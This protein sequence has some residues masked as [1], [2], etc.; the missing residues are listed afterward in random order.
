MPTK[1]GKELGK[2][3]AMMVLFDLASL[4]DVASTAL[5]DTIELKEVDGGLTLEE[6]RWRLKS[7]TV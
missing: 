1:E 6:S 5:V 7:G 3:R 4:S 2:N